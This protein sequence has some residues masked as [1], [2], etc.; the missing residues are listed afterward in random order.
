MSGPLFLA[1]DLDDP[2]DE[3]D[4]DFEWPALDAADDDDD[5]PDDD[6]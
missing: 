5:I 4:Y 3:D 6:E 1:P 2:E